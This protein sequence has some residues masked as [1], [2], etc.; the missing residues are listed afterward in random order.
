MIDELSNLYR[1]DERKFRKS[2]ELSKTEEV[3][4]E[5]LIAN[6]I[7]LGH[8]LE[9][10]LSNDKFELGR[11]FTNLRYIADVLK[12]YDRKGYD[13]SELGYQSAI[14]T[15]RKVYEIHKNTKYVK[16]VTNILSY[17]LREIQNSQSNT[18][19]VEVI[20]NVSKKQNK[21]KNF[22]ELSENRYSVRAFS[23]EPVEPSAIEKIVHISAKTPSVC[24]RQASRVRII[25]DKKIIAKILEVQGGM[26]GYSTPP[27]LMLITVDDS[28]FLGA[29]ERNQGFIDGGL[30]AMSILYSMEYEGLAACPLNCMFLEDKEKTIRGLLNIPETEKLIMFIACGHFKE[31][32][33]VCKSFRYP[34]E[35][36]LINVSELS[37]FK[38]SPEPPSEVEL[39]LR[40]RELELNTLRRPG[41]KLATRKLAGAVYRKIRK[42]AVGVG[43][44]NRRLIR[45]ARSYLKVKQQTRPQLS[46]IKADGA[47]LTICVYNN[48]GNILQ[49]FALQR[50]LENKGYNYYSL[51]M[52]D[53]G[54][55]R[56]EDI[57]PRFVEFANKYI[58]SDIFSNS[59]SKKYKSYIVGSDQIWRPQLLSNQ[60]GGVKSFFLDFI[61]NNKDVHRLSYAASFG[62]NRLKDGGYD[63]S[64]IQ[65]IKPLIGKFDKVSV[66]EESAKYLLE[67]LAGRNMNPELVVDPTLLLGVSE[68]D[69]IIGSMETTESQRVF[70]FC[71]DNTP[72]YD[73][74]LSLIKE[75]YG[76]FKPSW[77]AGV[78]EWLYNIKESDLVVTGSFHAVVF[79]IIFHT[80]FVVFNDENSPNYRV[81]NLLNNLGISDERIIENDNSASSFS[82]DN[83]KPIDWEAVDIK[84]NHLRKTSGEWLINSIKRERQ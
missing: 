13:K 29:H 48:F 2:L 80:Q 42:V 79:S 72:S 33:Y 58:K 4:Q 55:S 43:K 76:R 40:E 24:N 22:E 73:K 74:V 52:F 54:S 60:I 66:R 46:R 38:Y 25:Y 77:P 1:Y 31:S 84:I 36:F 64:L 82:L 28:S 70:Y 68:Y 59:T 30:Y 8:I 14:A 23:D 41:V 45:T 57:N 50:F 62:V 18:G 26:A 71:F 35:H 16:E 3:K 78:E 56:E 65:K 47:I 37:D 81:N 61:K 53:Y 21:K 83:L 49:R 15:V 6:I 27:C 67:E 9:K 11:S 63:E 17:S 51:D 75:K 7:L 12:T 10:S 19:G 69:D 44:K 34:A 39:L 32:N 5:Q 20:S